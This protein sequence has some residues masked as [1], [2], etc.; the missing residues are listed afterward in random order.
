[1]RNIVVTVLFIALICLCL[2]LAVYANADNVVG[3]IKIPSINA[4]FDL[5]HTYKECNAHQHYAEL[6]RTYGT[7]SVANHY[8]SMGNSGGQWKLENI[9]VGDK[10]YIEFDESNGKETKHFSYKYVCYAVL[11]VDT[12]YNVF[13]KHGEELRFYSKTDLICRTCVVSDSTRN[14]VAVFERAE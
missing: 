6:T 7:L 10:A 4:D 2:A 8:A 1:M 12:N 3:T 11:I 13:Y 9:H 5:V 14:Y